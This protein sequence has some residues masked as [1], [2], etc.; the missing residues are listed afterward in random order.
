MIVCDTT[1]HVNYRQL[2]RLISHF[3]IMLDNFFNKKD[4]IH[5][6]LSWYNNLSFGLCRSWIS[7][8]NIMDGF[9]WSGN[10][11]FSMEN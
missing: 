5:R 7:R 4:F 6:R 1:F 9:Y 10:R 3:A 2:N 8:S 11:R